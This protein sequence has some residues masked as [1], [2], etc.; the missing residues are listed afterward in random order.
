MYLITLQHLVGHT[1]HN[2]LRLITIKSDSGKIYKSTWI[3]VFA[4]VDRR[5][6]WVE[7]F[8]ALRRKSTDRGGRVT[9]C[10]TKH[11]NSSKLKSPH[12]LVISS[13]IGYFLPPTLACNPAVT[14][15]SP[16]WLPLTPICQATHHLGKRRPSSEGEWRSPLHHWCH[17][18]ESI[19]D[20]NSFSAE[21]PFCCDT[22][23][24]FEFLVVQ[25]EFNSNKK[26]CAGVLVGLGFA[27][28]TSPNLNL[29]N[30]SW[31]RQA[32]SPELNCELWLINKLN[33]QGWGYLYLQEAIWFAA[34]NNKYTV[35]NTK[36]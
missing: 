36:W 32:N 10:D 31:H 30:S 22:D 4:Q 21:I 7:T 19:H 11:W 9:H 6:L 23:F 20:S 1:H 17:A 3:P 16:C 25:L 34:S 18:F 13:H 15:L 24:Y 27:V 28:S 12:S 14:P 26:F 5:D 35:I 2:K 8:A 33:F 29:L